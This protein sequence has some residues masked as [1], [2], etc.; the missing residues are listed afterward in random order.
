MAEPLLELRNCSKTFGGRPA[1][2]DVGLDVHAGEVHAL[3]GQNGSG[4]STVIKVLAGYHAPD[5]GAS[6]KVHGEEVSLP[7]PPGRA[8]R[9]GLAFVHQDLGLA[10][11]LTVLENLRV[12]RFDPGLGWRIRWRFERQWAKKLLQRFDLDCSPDTR[13]GELREI[14]RAL[15]AIARGFGDLTA[16]GAGGVL[17]LDEPTAYLP[18]DSTEQLLDAIKAAAAGG[19]G[20]IFVTHRLREVHAIADTVTVLRD[21]RPVTTEPAAGLTE[22]ALAQRIL[23]FRL[24]ELYPLDHEPTGQIALQA[25]AIRGED[26]HPVTFEVREGEVLGVTGLVGMG[27]ERIPYLLFGA[28]GDA[29]GR[30]RIGDQERDVSQI[31]PSQAMA[32]GLALLPADRGRD[33]AA[34]VATVAENLSLPT[35]GRYFQGGRLRHRRER[36]RVRELLEAYDVHPRE[37]RAPFSTLSGGNKQRV[38]IA[39]WFETRPAVLLMHEPTHG[40]DVGA[41]QQILEHVGTAAREGQAFL[42]ASAE[43]EDLGHLCDRVLVFRDGRAVAELAGASLTH[44]RILE[45]CF[46]DEPFA[47]RHTEE[48]AAE[49]GEIKPPLIS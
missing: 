37:P 39:K 35:L 7:I 6:L 49:P 8:R 18:H 24:D 44:D 4:K 30:L 16:A 14:E 1:L 19:V 11:D 45:Q 42:I 48:T 26:M 47:T 5:P 12:G 38:L 43:Y 25:K 17:I 22:A 40:V 41:R 20:V 13:L 3:L 29:S 9:K 23:G 2:R 15:I 46:R 34:D 28:E 36:E 27:W 10:E 21:G 31:T 32:A 33:G